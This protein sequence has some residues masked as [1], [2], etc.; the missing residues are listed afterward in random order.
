[1]TWLG[2]LKLAMSPHHLGP[3]VLWLVLFS[4]GVTAFASQTLPP[5][6]TPDRRGGWNCNEGFLK[7]D[8]ACI[9]IAKATDAEIKDLLVQRSIAQYAGSCPCPFN[10]D[11]AGRRCGARSA[12]SR[13]GGAAPFCYA[14][15][16]SPKMV[17]EFRTR[18]GRHSNVGSSLAQ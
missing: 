15:D 11:R 4:A 18:Y 16:I 5:N 13:P 7:R 1:M 9:P 12:Y 6:A 3:R 17:A 8:R 2:G 14:S 10:A